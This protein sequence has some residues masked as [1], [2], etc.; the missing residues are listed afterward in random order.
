MQYSSNEDSPID[1][2]ASESLPLAGGSCNEVHVTRYVSEDDKCNCSFA[3]DADLRRKDVTD[4]VSDS[5]LSKHAAA[6][7]S[8]ELAD[9][10][11]CTSLTEP[12][13]SQLSSIVTVISQNHVA[14]DCFSNENST[15]AGGGQNSHIREKTLTDGRDSESAMKLYSHSSYGD[16]GDGKLSVVLISYIYNVYITSHDS[17]HDQDGRHKL[18]DQ[19]HNP[20]LRLISHSKIVTLK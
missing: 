9:R 1:H 15:D 3:A 16:G 8:D 18:Q 11:V 20:I 17:R 2:C 6:G 13:S 7:S 5:R 4:F 19:D 10:S 12:S 14:G